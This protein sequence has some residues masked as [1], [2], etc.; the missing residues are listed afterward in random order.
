M[1]PYGGVAW[2]PA[3]TPEA[4]PGGR[5]SDRR[6]ETRRRQGPARR[7][8]RRPLR[9]GALPGAGTW[10][11]QYGNVANTSK[12]DDRLVRLPLGLLWFGGNT[13]ADV[14]PRH[15]HGPPEQVLGGRLFIE[16]VNSLSARDVYTGRRLWK[17]DFED[18]GTFGVYFDATYR[19]DPLDTTYNQVHIPGANARGTNFVVTPD[20][21]YLAFGDGCEVMDPATGE[22]LS[23]FSLPAEP[24]AKEKPTWGY[25]GV[26]DDVLVAGSRFVRF[27]TQYKVASEKVW[28]N[29]DTSSSRKLVAMDR[30]TGDV[31]WTRESEFAFRHN[32]ITAGGGKLFVIDSLPEPILDALRRRG[33]SPPGKSR[34]LALDL[35]TGRPVWSRDEDVFG[36]WLSY[37]AAHDVL[38]QSGRG[39]RD[40][41]VGEPTDRMMALR[42]AT[43]DVVWDKPV[44]HGGPAMIHGET[45]YLNAVRNEGAA[46]EL[47]DRQREDAA[48]SLDR[49]AGPVEVPPRVRVQFGLGRRVPLGLPQRHGGLL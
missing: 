2:I 7:R 33:E 26:A 4:T 34:L 35:K 20:R 44:E 31:L 27:S 29:F 41:I 5:T 40:M 45:I 30:H 28:D 19:D 15:G 42:G 22:T 43:G 36:T 23:R 21:V 16:G 47:L 14:L 18:L 24:E 46:V 48:E 12:S 6:G 8:L 17:R 25:I 13:H 49:P 3:K 1:R 11:H 32:A 39:S 10:T 9:E 37:D 38:L